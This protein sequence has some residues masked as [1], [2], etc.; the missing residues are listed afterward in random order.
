[1]KSTCGCGGWHRNPHIGL[2]VLRVVTGF[3]FIYHGLLKFQD[4]AG[5][6]DFFNFLNLPVWLAPFVASVEV[7]GGALLVLGLFTYISSILLGLDM[8]GAMMFVTWHAGGWGGSEFEFLLLASLIAINSVGTGRYKVRG[9]C[10]YPG[11]TDSQMCV[12]C[13]HE[14]GGTTCTCECHN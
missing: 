14:R 6:R 10:G 9:R 8:I 12:D 5:T 7:I 11:C 1:M 4:M 13:G 3:I 2:F